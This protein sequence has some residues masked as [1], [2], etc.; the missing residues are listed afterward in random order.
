MLRVGLLTGKTEAKQ[1]D[2]GRTGIGEVV[3]CVCRNRDGTG[4]GSGK[5]LDSKEEQIQ[6]DAADTT[7]HTVGAADTGVLKI[8]MVRYEKF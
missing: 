8:G 6:D 5:E 1:C 4:Q 7:K 2:N 3:E